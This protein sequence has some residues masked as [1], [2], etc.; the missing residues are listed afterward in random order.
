VNFLANLTVLSG[1]VAI[2]SAIGP[3]GWAALGATAIV[4]WKK[5]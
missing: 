1:L 4:L 3:W 2:A 5:S